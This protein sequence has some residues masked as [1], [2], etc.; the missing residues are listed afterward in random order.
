MTSL[1]SAGITRSGVTAL[2]CIALLSGLLT[3]MAATAQAHNK[4]SAN[5]YFGDT[6]RHRAYKPW[7]PNST[8]IRARSRL[9]CPYVVHKVSLGTVLQ[10]RRVG[11]WTIKAQGAQTSYHVKNESALASWGCRGSG[12]QKY[13]AVGRL[14]ATNNQGQ[15]PVVFYTDAVKT[16][17][18]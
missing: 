10:Q 12:K 16:L 8:T 1:R 9:S 7:K 5:C 15:N 4:S 11:Y 3:S 2:L 13:R 18:C 17:S 14:T 6:S